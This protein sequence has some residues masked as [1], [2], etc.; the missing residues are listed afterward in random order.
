IVEGVA[1]SG[2]EF[3]QGRRPPQPLPSRVVEAVRDTYERG[4]EAFGAVRFEWVYDGAAVWVV[5]LHRGTTGSLG[6]TIYPGEATFIHR[7]QV[8]EGLEALRS[9]IER[10][11]PGEG[12]VLVGNVG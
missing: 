6:R 5:Q 7:F 10:I 12:I 9:L 8:D 2:E 1:G 3:M 11:E 4:I